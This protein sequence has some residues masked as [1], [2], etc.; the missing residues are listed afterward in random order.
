MSEKAR[1]HSTKK[2]DLTGQRLDSYCTQARDD[3]LLREWHPTWNGLLTPADVAPHSN[4]KVWWRCEKG[5]SWETSV[6]NRVSG[7]GCPVCANRRV[8]RGYN[9]LASTCPEAA[10]Q[11]DAEK[12]GILTPC[13]V[14]PCSRQRVWW[15]C[16]KGHSWRTTVSNRVSHGEGCPVCAGRTVAAG[17]NDF[18]TL[19]PLLAAEFDTEMNAPLTP[20]QLSPHTN[21]K[22]W[23]RCPL[24]H[25]YSATVNSRTSRQTSCPY[26]AG[27]KVLPG[28][29][30]LATAEPKVAAQWHPTLNG[31]MTPQMIT[32][33]SHYKAWWVC[34][35]GH[36]WK[37]TVVSRAGKKKTG[38]PVCAGTVKKQR[39][40]RYRTIM[41]TRV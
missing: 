38:C 22:V 40:A 20:S 2:L 36:V 15:R 19:F 28:F 26:C 14:A 12:N 35:D 25:S 27:R 9:D 31:A 29:N 11:W 37:A 17:E 32:F 39:I 1:T 4:K 13:D 7:C 41:E 24:G 33:G 8:E 3:T 10:A 23:W 16:A 18:E 34:E 6:N 21:R 5:H 30:D